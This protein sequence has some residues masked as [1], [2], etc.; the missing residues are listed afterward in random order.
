MLFFIEIKRERLFLYLSLDFILI[1]YIK[2]LILFYVHIHRDKHQRIKIFIAKEIRFDN[3][4]NQ[5]KQKKRKK[6]LFFYN[7]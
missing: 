6:I 4:I 5:K 3:V 7:N 1:F 2:H